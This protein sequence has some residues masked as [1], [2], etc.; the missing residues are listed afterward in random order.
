[1]TILILRAYM[2]PP[3]APVGEGSGDAAGPQGFEMKIPNEVGTAWE[4]SWDESGEVPLFINVGSDGAK[5][6][7]KGNS[8]PC[9]G[10][11]EHIAQSLHL[12]KTTPIALTAPR[13]QAEKL[14][15]NLAELLKRSGYSQAAVIEVNPIEESK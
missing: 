5:C 8:M 15:S 13:G 6:T 4:K 11:V 9:S 12:P 3:P 1:M 7:I 2:P 14:R 10:V